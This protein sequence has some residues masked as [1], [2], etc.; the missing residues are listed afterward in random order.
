[1]APTTGYDPAA[2]VF[3]A[4]RSIRLSEGGKVGLDE[5]I[6]N[7]DPS[8]PNGVLYQAELHLEMARQGGFGPPIAGSK[9]TVL[10]LHYC[11]IYLVIVPVS[12]TYMFLLPKLI[13]WFSSIN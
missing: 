12:A 5:S 11:L 10:P 7:S 9:P 8:A 4:Q 13:Y 6:R 1:M 3:V 2:F